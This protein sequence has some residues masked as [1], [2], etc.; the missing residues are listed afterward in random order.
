MWGYDQIEVRPD[1][2]RGW[3]NYITKLRDK[4]DFASAIDWVNVRLP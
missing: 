3:L 4:P 2:D 1:A